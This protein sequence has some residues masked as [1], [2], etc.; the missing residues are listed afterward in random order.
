MMNCL[1]VYLSTMMGFWSSFFGCIHSEFLPREVMG[2]FG[3]TVYYSWRSLRKRKKKKKR[4]KQPCNRD[5]CFF[6]ITNLQGVSFLLGHIVSISWVVLVLD[7]FKIVLSAS[8]RVIP[9]KI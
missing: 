5:S 4:K 3:S 9:N 7:L 1:V 8:D 6:F 2:K